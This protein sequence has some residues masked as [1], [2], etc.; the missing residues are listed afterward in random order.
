MLLHAS[1][2][3]FN[4]SQIVLHGTLFREMLFNILQKKRKRRGKGGRGRER[5]R[6]VKKRK[7]K[8]AC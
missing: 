2:F 8:A 4:I 1:F 5:E 7:R 6:K 3:I